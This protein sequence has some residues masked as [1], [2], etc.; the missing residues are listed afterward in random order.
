MTDI[1]TGDELELMA[2]LVL[3]AVLGGFM[4]LERE[5]RGYPAGIRTLALVTV[6]STLFTEVSQLM[7][8]DDRVAA[9]IVT[10]IGFIGAG[11]FFREGYTVRGITTAATIWAAAAVGMAIGIQLYIVAVGGAIL[12][13]AVLEARPFTRRVE[14]VISARIPAL[15]Q[16]SDENDDEGDPATDED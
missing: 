9:Q 8:G 4:G 7:G 10:G 13:F 15:A 6:G 2:R 11:L 14:Q 16:R 5:L 12:V 1:S 3:A